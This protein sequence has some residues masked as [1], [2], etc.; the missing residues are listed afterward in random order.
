MERQCLGRLDD[1]GSIWWIGHGQRLLYND[2]GL[3][4]LR[5]PILVERRQRLRDM[6][7]GPDGLLDIRTRED[8]GAL[9]SI[10]PAP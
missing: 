8:P 6:H 7:Q 5:T 9:R 2:Q 10:G 1:A 3:L 4:M